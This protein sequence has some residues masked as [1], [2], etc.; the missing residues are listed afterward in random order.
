MII[1]NFLFLPNISSYGTFDELFILVI[2]QGRVQGYVGYAF[3]NNILPEEMVRADRYDCLFLPKINDI[4]L[5]KVS[6]RV[7]VI[8]QHGAGQYGQIIIMRYVKFLVD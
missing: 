8:A 3:I 6:G 7:A 2:P 4:I 5:R 1:Q